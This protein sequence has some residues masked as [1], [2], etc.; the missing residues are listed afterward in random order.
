MNLPI[1]NRIEPRTKKQVKELEKYKKSLKITTSEEEF[2]LKC[3]LSFDWSR[4]IIINYIKNIKSSKRDGI[5]FEL[6]ITA[7]RKIVSY[8]CGNPYESKGWAFKEFEERADYIYNQL[9]RY[10]T[11]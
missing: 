9:Y 11:I 1:Y 8:S 5:R 3:F 6:S 7:P 10:C 4:Q 2:V